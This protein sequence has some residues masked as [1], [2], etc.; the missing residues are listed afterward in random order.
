MIVSTAA[1]ASFR[2][3]DLLALVQDFHQ[4][5]FRL[6]I[7]DDCPQ[8]DIDVNVVPV[9]S[10]LMLS[11][12]SIAVARNYVPSVFKVKQCPVLFVAANDHMASATSIT[13]IGS[14]FGGHAV[15]HK[16]R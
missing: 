13:S 8:R 3:N 9:R 7:P 15:A 6:Y 1:L 2:E 11:A 14:A 5:F 10:V 16:V 4:H 12:T